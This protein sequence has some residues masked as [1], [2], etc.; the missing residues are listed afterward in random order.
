MAPKIFM[1]AP[2]KWKYH[3]LLI[4]GLVTYQIEAPDFKIT[5]IECLQKKIGG[6]GFR[7]QK[8]PKKAKFGPFLLFSL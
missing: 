8:G 3:I 2:K 7:G 1:E 5:K 4:Y 6:L